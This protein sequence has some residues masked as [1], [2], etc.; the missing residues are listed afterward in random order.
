MKFYPEG[1][2]IPI[3]SN[4]KT[5][6]IRWKQYQ[7]KIY[8]KEELQH[9]NNC[10]FAIICGKTSNNL[11]II[12]PDFK[13]KRNFE[14][15]FTA[16]K[17]QFPELSKTYIVS[18]PH[19]YHLYYYMIG[20]SAKRTINK[21]IIT[22][23]VR[24]KEYFCGL[25]KTKF[26]EYLKGI[27]FLGNKGYALI[28]PS[29]IDDLEYT[30]LTN[31]PVREILEEEYLQIS[32]F[33]LL[34]KPIQIR[35]PFLDILNGEIEIEEYATKHNKNE[36][37]YWKFLFREAYHF[38]KLI[39][40][41]LFPFLRK[42]QPSFDLEETNFQLNHDYHSYKGKDLSNEKMKEYFPDYTFNG[43][44]SFTNA[45]LT[46]HKFINLTLEEFNLY[47]S[48]FLQG[49]KLSEH[50]FD[51]NIASKI[52][53]KLINLLFHIDKLSIKVDDCDGCG[54]TTEIKTVSFKDLKGQLFKIREC[55][56]CFET[57]WKMDWDSYIE[58]QVILQQK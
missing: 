55:K 34:D 18:T 40:E 56:H 29:T 24:D 22:K 48:E 4:G 3:I 44:N 49:Y 38:C 30:P 20:F 54:I 14:Y 50:F 51:N 23:T 33:F 47:L 36:F 7:A 31:Y 10:N 16:F 8:S 19:G 45:N 2:I 39:P 6:L 52:R 41:E 37:I 21:N 15:V 53:T 5:P 27:D 1:N 57:D 35:K 42:N 58:N 46:P 9:Y 12:D 17:E 25:I 13:N 32:Q 26:A 28:P 43:D 11:L